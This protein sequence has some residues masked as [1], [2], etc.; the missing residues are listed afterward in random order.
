[1]HMS[2]VRHSAL[3]KDIFLQ[4]PF[5]K[6]NNQPIKK[7]KKA[8]CQCSHSWE[9]W[10]I[11]FL[12]NTRSNSPRFYRVTVSVLVILQV[13]IKSSFLNDLLQL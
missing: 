8:P 10:K 5:L 2:D 12:Q 6:N 3:K 4:N 13:F 9:Y 1:M 11:K 7:K